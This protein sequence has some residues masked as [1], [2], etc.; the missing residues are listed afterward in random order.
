MKKLANS[1]PIPFVAL[2]MA[3]GVLLGYFGGV[4]SPFI[5][6]IGLAVLSV[7][8]IGL[9][10][11]YKTR[12][13]L[14]VSLVVILF[15]CLGALLITNAINVYQSAGPYDGKTLQVEGT[16]E[17]VKLIDEDLV[18]LTLSDVRI[19]DERVSFKIFAYVSS[20][21]FSRGETIIFSEKLTY[22]SINPQNLESNTP[23]SVTVKNGL[24]SAEDSKARFTL[25]NLVSRVIRKNLKGDSAAICLG[26]LLG[27]T[28]YFKESTLLNYQMSG[29]CHVFAVSGLHV[30]FFSS[31]ILRVLSLFKV[32]GIK[33][34]VLSTFFT[35]LYAGVCGFPY[36][37]IRATIMMAVLSLTK[38]FGRKYDGINSLFFSFSVILLIFP[39]AIF[40]YGFWLSFLAVIGINTLSRNVE[41]ALSFMPGFLSSSLSVS[42]AVSVI[43][44]PLLMQM[45]GYMSIIVIFLNV[46]IIPMITFLYSLTFVVTLIAAILPF[47]GFLFALPKW[48]ATFINGFMGFFDFERFLL[49]GKISLFALLLYYLLYA[50]FSN[51]TNFPKYVKI[52]AGVLSLVTVALSS[53]GLI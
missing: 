10:F 19:N 6:I 36:S 38:A 7:L 45:S 40:S 27:D 50:V 46:L 49:Y 28:S 52:T 43:T 13:N 29:V 44:T 37:A 39:A 31:I 5:P 48:V 3:A 41:S 21:R 15:F 9:Y 17:D 42:V 12:K 35:L 47:M 32:K 14:T 33:S 25:F 8:S 1:R 18:G 4:I 2:S 11:A 53:G 34:T 16:V 23:L 26:V 51:R 20:D 24:V 22:K 30:A